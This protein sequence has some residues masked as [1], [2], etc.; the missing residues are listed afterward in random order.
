MI[1]KSADEFFSD[2][3][4]FF[5][6]LGIFT[7]RKYIINDAVNLPLQLPQPMGSQLALFVAARPWSLP[8]SFVPCLLATLASL[9]TAHAPNALRA[10]APISSVTALHLAANLRACSFA[11]RFYSIASFS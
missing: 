6:F 7:L 10:A 11:S 3:A 5:H 2:A 4:L 1:A 8:A 9:G